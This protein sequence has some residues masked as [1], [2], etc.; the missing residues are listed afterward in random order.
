MAWWP[1]LPVSAAE[2]LAVGIPDTT[3]VVFEDS[4][5][6]GTRRPL[7]R[8]K[9]LEP[10]LN[11]FITVMPERGREEAREAER[12]FSR[13]KPPVSRTVSRSP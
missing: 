10:R 12:R 6:R 9:E 2:E 1:V 7:E 8:L 13:G 4:A 5:G 3:L 11:A